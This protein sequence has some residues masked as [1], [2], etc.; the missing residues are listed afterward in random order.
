MI[1]KRED[2]CQIVIP[3]RLASSRLP[4]K[5]LRHA[6]GKSVLQH[7]YEAACR[8][9]CT[10][11][12]IVA[13][14]DD[15][16]AEEVQRFGGKWIMTSVDC[17]S[18]TDRIAEV[19]AALPGKDVFVNVQGDEPEIDPAVIDKVAARLIED[20]TADLATAGVA[21]RDLSTLEDPSN[22]KIVMAGM[23]GSSSGRAVYFSRSVVP[24]VRGGITAESL[25]SEPPIFWHHIGLYAYRRSFLQWFADQPVSLLETTEKLEQLRAVEAGK[26]IVVT[27]IQRGTPGIDTMEDLEAFRQRIDSGSVRID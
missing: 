11:D 19:A 8:A 2:Y 18:G 20:T 4:E 15:R 13:V 16:L 24:H 17:A 7:T 9:S 6:G 25:A 14:D 3:A 1:S 5:L 21:I 22:V 12:V 27:Q 10:D 26:R 23:D